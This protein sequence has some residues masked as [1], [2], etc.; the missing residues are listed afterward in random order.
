MFFSLGAVG[1]RHLEGKAQP[2]SLQQ[3]DDHPLWPVQNQI[4]EGVPQVILQQQQRTLENAHSNTTLHR[5]FD[6]ATM[7]SDDLN[8]LNF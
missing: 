6:W 5:C 7:A 8:V 2:Q 4:L 1:H 3:E